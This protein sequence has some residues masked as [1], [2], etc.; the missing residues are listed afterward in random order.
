MPPLSEHSE[1]M[2]AFILLMYD[3]TSAAFDPSVMRTVIAYTVCLSVKHVVR[4]FPV[5]RINACSSYR[6]FC[7]G[8][9][10]SHNAQRR[11]HGAENQN[12]VAYF[13][14][15]GFRVFNRFCIGIQTCLS[16]FRKGFCAGDTFQLPAPCPR[17]FLPLF[18]ARQIYRLP[19]Y[20]M[21]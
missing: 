4:L 7:V 1:Q 6:C 12:T 16:P 8:P 3:K 18:S 20:R 17:S 13:I 11:N 19:F 14:T 21:L 15:F 10:I 9:E 2:V 5:Y